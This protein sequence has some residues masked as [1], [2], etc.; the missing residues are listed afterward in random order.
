MSED[1]VNLDDRRSTEGQMATDFRRHALREFEA[2][3]EALRKRQDELEAQLL[4][5]PSVTWL[6][7][8]VKAQYLI[9]RYAETT[10]ARDA[11]KQK[12]IQRALG[13][14]ARLIEGEPKKHE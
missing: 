12:L 3:Q 10:E 14:L 11:R 9:R 6:E 13:D 5:E 8:A 2:D 1:P 4:A 7:A